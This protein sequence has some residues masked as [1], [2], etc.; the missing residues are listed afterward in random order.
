MSDEQHPAAAAAGAAGP[1]GSSVRGALPVPP[2]PGV[3]PPLPVPL[4]RPSAG[5]LGAISVTIPDP[6]PADIG[7]DSRALC[8]RIDMVYLTLA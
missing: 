7:N 3:P 2:V 5:P 4:S 6:A 1:G 8:Y